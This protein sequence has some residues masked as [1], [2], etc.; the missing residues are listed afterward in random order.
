[1]RFLR[2]VVAKMCSTRP[3][4]VLVIRPRNITTDRSDG[5]SSSG[6]LPFEII[7]EIN[8]HNELYSYREVGS[9]IEL[10]RFDFKRFEFQSDMEYSCLSDYHAHDHTISGDVGSD[11]DHM[12]SAE[13][14]EIEYQY[15]GFSRLILSQLNTTHNLFLVLIQLQYTQWKKNPAS[16]KCLVLKVMPLLKINVSLAPISKI[17]KNH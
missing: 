9:N 8:G 12:Y 17:D 1:M 3:S 13:S 4:K 5:D 15:S 2:I 6:D 7:E 10:Q 14:D 16:T 11:P